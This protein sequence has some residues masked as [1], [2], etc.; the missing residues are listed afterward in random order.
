LT[1]IAA[2]SI[3]KQY[4]PHCM[5][6]MDNFYAG[7]WPCS[8]TSGDNRCV[9]VANKHPKGHQSNTGKIFAAGDY[10]A[11]QMDQQ[12]TS[13]KFVEEVASFYKG[14]WSKLKTLD[15]ADKG[16]MR[17]AGAKNQRQ[18]LGR[19]M[20]QR[21]LDG[22]AGRLASHSTCFGCLFH[23]P[24]HVLPC[25]HVI[26]DACLDDFS[27]QNGL[28][29]AIRNCPLCSEGAQAIPWI[30]NKQPRQASPRILSLDG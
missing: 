14:F 19:P 22:S 12:S 4:E 3:L 25:G 5:A 16:G 23:T 30:H 7:H 9:N 13:R 27:D 11:E 29:R 26:C 15:D 24:A 18:I 17:S 2:E 1:A 21:I 28:M 8:Y 6:A 20:F 10:Q